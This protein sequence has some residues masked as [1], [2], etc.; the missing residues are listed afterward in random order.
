MYYIAGP[1]FNKEQTKVIKSIEELL[2]SREEEYFS[3]REYGVI[4]DEPMT[5]E[6]MKRIFDMN[7]LMLDQAEA[8][9]AILDDRDTGTIFELGYFYAT[10]KHMLPGKRII[11][12]SSQGYG[13]NVM[14]KHAVEFHCNG[15]TELNEA[16]NGF[17][18]NDLEVTE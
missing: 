11:T 13:I 15:L 16:L 17:G 3:P 14:L 1:L 4:A 2:D 5:S 12:F 7:I 18:A 10:C 6:R 8:L 9:I